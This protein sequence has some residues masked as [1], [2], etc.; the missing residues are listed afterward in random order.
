MI[1]MMVLFCALQFQTDEPANGRFK[2][3]NGSIYT[4]IRCL[5]QL[6]SSLQYKGR[7]SEFLWGGG[8]PDKRFSLAIRYDGSLLKDFS[9]ALLVLYKVSFPHQYSLQARQGLLVLCNKRYQKFF[10]CVDL[11][12][13]CGA[14]SLPRAWLIKRLLRRLISSQYEFNY[15]SIGVCQH[16]SLC[17]ACL[18][19]DNFCQTCLEVRH[20]WLD[21]MGK[22]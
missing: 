21:Q 12:L 10:R 8:S 20:K 22:F 17:F 15:L 18:L 7:T 3:I 4:T 5:R 19:L 16:H 9:Q 6:Q 1:L 14:V 11:F 13:L 2:L